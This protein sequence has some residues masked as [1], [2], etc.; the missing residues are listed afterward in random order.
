LSSDDTE[1]LPRGEELRHAA[2]SRRNNPDAPAR[3]L[4]SGQVWVPGATPLPSFQGCRVYAARAP[5]RA[6][7]CK[8]SGREPKRRVTAA[9]IIDVG[10]EVLRQQRIVDLEHVLRVLLP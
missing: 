7:R 3:I 4:A 10:A 1:S 6:A 2:R 5:V 8:D 9:H